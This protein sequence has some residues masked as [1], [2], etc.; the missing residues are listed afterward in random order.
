MMRVLVT[1]EASGVV[2]DAF[3][4]RGHDAWSCDL[5][6][7]EGSSEFHIRGDCFLAI[8]SA[9]WDLLISHPSCQF[10]S[11]SGLHWNKRGRIEQGR[12]RAEW[13]EEAIEHVLELERRSQ[14]IKRAAFENPIGC[15][16]T[17]WR[18][19]DQ[20]IQPHQFGEDASKATCLWLRRLP[21]LTPTL[22]V[23]GRIVGRDARGK[24]ILRWANQTDSGQNKLTPSAERWI[25]R[26][27]TYPGIAEAFAAQWG[28][29]FPPEGLF[30]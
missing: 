9:S 29:D 7:A 23:P 28:G 18:K 3:R 16:S 13:T 1:H 27:R 21:K 5:R 24:P 30:H 11:V 8:E 17:R 19:P 22:H 25:E 20:I 2:R 26:S 10:L 12:P 4:R 14:H 15:L 6:E